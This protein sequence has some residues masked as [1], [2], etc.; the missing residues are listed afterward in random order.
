[1]YQVLKAGEE[2]YFVGYYVTS[3]E[4]HVVSTWVTYEDAERA[5][6]SLNGKY[7]KWVN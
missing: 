5:R 6:Q 2:T 1:M 3:G 4:F 7:V